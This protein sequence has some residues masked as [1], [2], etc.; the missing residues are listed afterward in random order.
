[1]C[2]LQVNSGEREQLLSGTTFMLSKLAT[3]C[4]TSVNFHC[5]ID[6]FVSNVLIICNTIIQQNV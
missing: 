1:V 4:F 6:T 3:F 2:V 5:L